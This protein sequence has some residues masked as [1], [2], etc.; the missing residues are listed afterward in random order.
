MNFSGIKY[1]DKLVLAALACVFLS[2]PLTLTQ[3]AITCPCSELK[4]PP[5]PAKDIDPVGG[6]AFM[7]TPEYKKEFAD[8]IAGARKAC[9]KHLG[10][11]NVAIVS[12]I[13]ETCLDNSEHFKSG[14]GWGD[15]VSW[16]AEARDPVLKQTA[17]FL[18]WARKNGFAVFFITG[19]SEVSRAATIR[20]LVR[21]G[22]SYDGLY[23]RPGNDDLPAADFKA[24]YRKK[25]A[26]M[27]FNIIVNIGDQYSD[28]K[29]G[30]AEDCEKLPNKIYYIK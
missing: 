10:E 9:M 22:L 19:R 21:A 17:D 1:G 25:I 4:V 15:W 11:K 30:Y 24:S 18:A 20:N 3:A 16:E 26:D 28:L 5:A 7:K 14:T 23:M 6:L 8:A 27:G 2:T 29:G 13:D 12:D